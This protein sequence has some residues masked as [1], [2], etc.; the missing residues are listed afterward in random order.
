MSCLPKLQITHA[1][2]RKENGHEY[3]RPDAQEVDLPA[4]GRIGGTSLAFHPH[5]GPNASRIIERLIIFSLR[6]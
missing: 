2:Q 4:V 3:A 5:V 6:S 1:S